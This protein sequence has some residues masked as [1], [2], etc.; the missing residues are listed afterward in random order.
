VTDGNV[1]GL[2]GDFEYINDG[3]NPRPLVNN[4]KKQ[5]NKA[6]MTNSRATLHS[7]QGNRTRKDASKEKRIFSG[8]PRLK[9]L[10]SIYLRKFG[11]SSSHK[12]LNK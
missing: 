5:I 6:F 11:A 9:G 7:H 12:N 2:S 1:S 4:L 3:L 10:E 8:D